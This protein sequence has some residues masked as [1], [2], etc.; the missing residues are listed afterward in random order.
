MHIRYVFN[1]II[2]ALSE[3]S[4][5]QFLQWVKI[6]HGLIIYISHAVWDSDKIFHYYF[7]SDLILIV[8]PFRTS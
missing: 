4:D 2:Y 5:V 6:I 3:R 1:I 8:N 7:V